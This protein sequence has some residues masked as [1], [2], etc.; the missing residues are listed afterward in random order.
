MGR[1]VEHGV[2]AWGRAYFSAVRQDETLAM[3]SGRHES[4]VN[5]HGLELVNCQFQRD[6]EEA[7][8]I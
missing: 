1:G 2:K 5:V 3:L 7:H 8:S 4:R 6:V